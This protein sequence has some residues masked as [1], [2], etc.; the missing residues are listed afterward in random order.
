MID[1]LGVA[2]YYLRAKFR[3]M[4]KS[5]LTLSQWQEKQVIKHVR[6]VRKHSAFYSTLWDGLNDS[7]W[8]SFPIIDKE[9][10]MSGFD[11]LNTVGISKQEALTTAM[12]AERS[13]D[14]KPQIGSVTI[15]LSS[16]TS[17]NRGLFLISQQEQRAWAGTI[18]AKLLPKSILQREK[19]AFFL[20]A[21][22]N[23][24][25][26]VGSN[27]IQF[28]YYDLLHPIKQHIENLNT[29][30][31]GIIAAPP[32]MLRILAEAKQSG[33]LSVAPHRL[34]GV[35]EV[36]D[37]LDKTFIEQ[38][39]GQIVHQI[40]QCTEGFLGCTC[41]YGTMHI[42]EDI[43]VVE[44]EYLDKKLGRFV[45]VITDF[46]RR[47]QP[48]VRYRLNDVLV[49]RQEPCPCGSPFLALEAVE[50]RCD[51]IFYFHRTDT[52]ELQA[53]FPDFISRAI[54]QASDRLKEYFVVQ[55]APDRLQIW[56]RVENSALLQPSMELVEKTKQNIIT[57]LQQLCLKTG[58][59][60]PIIEFEL[61]ERADDRYH[62][63]GETRKL[64]RVERRFSCKS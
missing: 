26:S 45:P 64:R 53:I 38:Q 29:Q 59:E 24:Y 58:S 11:E 30:Q 25:N 5:R 23:L 35:A 50:G 46:S 13:R 57:E 44:K 54:I 42:N 3:R 27:R 43:V 52:R 19:I 36:L 22:S 63:A 7:D 34:I 10:M 47:A 48:I 39:F 20:R 37:K 8:R 60:L 17:G 56:L 12:E 62:I 51:D 61:M 41:A 1:Q 21:N 55:H 28:Q 33:L 6:D 14:F 16:G 9:Q 18:L 2:V 31:P 32:S 15:G 4:P 49:E 40:Y